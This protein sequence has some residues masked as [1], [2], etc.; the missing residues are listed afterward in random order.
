MLDTAESFCT[1]IFMKIISYAQQSS[2][3]LFTLL[4]ITDLGLVEITFSG[5]A[6]SEFYSKA[7]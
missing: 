2:F 5:T 4:A 7:S 6:L 1:H 3:I